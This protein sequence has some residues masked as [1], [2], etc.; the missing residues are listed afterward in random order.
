[1]EVLYERQDDY[2]LV[3]A[4]DCFLSR[5]LARWSGQVFSSAHKLGPVLESDGSPYA[6]QSQPSICAGRRRRGSDYRTA[7]HYQLD[8]A[9][10]VPGQYLAAAECDQPGY[11]WPILRH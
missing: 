1:M 10:S 11:D 6:G 2:R 4:E 3:V 8:P 5:A 7:G 9:G